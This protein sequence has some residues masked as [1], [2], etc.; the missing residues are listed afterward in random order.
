MKEQAILPGLLLEQNRT[1]GGRENPGSALYNPYIKEGNLKAFE[2]AGAYL[3]GARKE[4]YRTT[5]K[6][7]LSSEKLEEHACKTSALKHGLYQE[8]EKKGFS[9]EAMWHAKKIVDAVATRPVIQEG[10]DEARADRIR[11]RYIR[12]AGLLR[13]FLLSNPDLDA[14]NASWFSFLEQNFFNTQADIEKSAVLNRRVRK[15]ALVPRDWKSR[16]PDEMKKKQFRIDPA[17]RLPSGFKTV[18][19]PDLG[20]YRLLMRKN[21]GYETV[22]ESFPTLERAVSFAKE[23]C[24]KS[25]A[26]G[27]TRFPRPQFENLIIEGR[28]HP[29]DETSSP[30]ELIETF[31]LRGIQFG[32]YLSGEDRMQAV[33]FAH[34]AFFDLSLALEVKPGAV[35]L[36]RTLGLSFGARGKGNAMA[37]YEPDQRVINL[38]KNAGMSGTLAH[39]YGHALHYRIREISPERAVKKDLNP[40]VLHL[41]A[42]MKEKKLCQQDLLDEIA[43]A[44]EEIF[45]EMKAEAV[46][47]QDDSLLSY[48]RE[49]EKLFTFDHP[50]QAGD[51]RERKIISRMPVEM[52]KINEK[53]ARML[54]YAD[55][56]VL[57]DYAGIVEKL[58]EGV[59]VSSSTDYYR[60]SQVFDRNFSREGGYWASDEELFARA[61]SCFVLDRLKEK[62]IRNDFLTAASQIHELPVSSS[63]SKRRL[64]FEDGT[65]FFYPLPEKE[66]VLR[67]YPVFEERARIN[68]AFAELMEALRG[69]GVFEC[70]CS[71]H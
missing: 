24:R 65:V 66:D 32:N 17:K 45:T 33:S 51:I 54:S 40:E 23:Q 62:G 7:G 70:Y 19:D 53:A 34:A 5:S 10:V 42:V 67:A 43:K 56:K 30:E 49:K 39:E 35:S 55:R 28:M 27:K 38:T 26:R 59:G 9:R 64:T 48:L 31:G 41:L 47:L 15:K 11:E 29:L 44:P 61:F 8:M 22:Q 58:K 60:A 69:T 71:D 14:F 25:R 13:G 46:R 21:G 16:Y 68:Q 6:D 1:K 3:P 36:G 2:D 37:H 4:L 57:E 18:Y 50:L 20:A 63:F 12:E 52:M